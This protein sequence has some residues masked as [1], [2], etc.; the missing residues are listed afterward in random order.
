M[1]INKSSHL[2]VIAASLL[3]M[4]AINPVKALA[5]EGQ[6]LEPSSPWKV[7]YADKE[8]RLLRDFGSGDSAVTMRLA[9]ASGLDSFDLVVAGTAIPRLPERVELKFGLMPQGKEES[10]DAYSLRVPG[11]AIRFIRWFD[12][13]PDILTAVTNDQIVTIKLTDK[14]DIAM[15]WKDGKAALRALEDCHADLMKSW[16][17][18]VALIRSAKTR[19]TP[20]G[21]P[22]R[23][24]TN[25]DYPNEAARQGLEGDVVFQLTIDPRSEERRVGKECRS[26][27]SPYH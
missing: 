19:A 15:R 21:S 16:G 25:S 12:A 3:A 20:T 7:D 4:L 17:V 10:V 26:R 5:F 2:A 8:C 24:A 23:W 27:W 1:A 13:N 14:V 9:R 11:Q 22:G 18:D 6:I